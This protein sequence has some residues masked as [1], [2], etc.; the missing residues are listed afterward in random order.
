VRREDFVKGCEATFAE[1]LEIIRR[2]NA[3]YSGGADDAFGNFAAAEFFGVTTM[4]QAVFIRMLD[5]VTRLSSF[6][7]AKQLQVREESVVDTLRDLANYAVILEQI[8]KS[9]K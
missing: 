2:K 4:E 1:M 8:I 9:R 7:A 6:M 3:D 5:K